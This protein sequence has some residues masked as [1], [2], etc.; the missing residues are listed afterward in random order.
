M[1]TDWI[2]LAGLCDD[3]HDCPGVFLTPRG[4][5]A[6]QGE[7]IQMRTP[8]GESMVEIPFALLIEAARAAR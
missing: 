6:V 8:P 4:T 3:E 5:V 1:R 2:K 7:H